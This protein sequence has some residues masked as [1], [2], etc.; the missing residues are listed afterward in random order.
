M[1][2]PPIEIQGSKYGSQTPKKALKTLLKDIKKTQR[3][4]SRFFRLFLWK[5]F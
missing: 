5:G 4:G 2:I 1:K 3:H